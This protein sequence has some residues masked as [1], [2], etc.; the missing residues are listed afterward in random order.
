MEGIPCKTPT[1]LP[2]EIPI[3]VKIWALR[4]LTPLEFQMGPRTMRGVGGG[5]GGD[6][7]IL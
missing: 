3:A 4:P 5:G 2:L 6:V 7:N 1:P